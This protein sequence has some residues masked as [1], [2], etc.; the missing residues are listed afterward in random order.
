MTAAVEQVWLDVREPVVVGVS[1]AAVAVRL[2]QR[3]GVVLQHSVG[4]DLHGGCVVVAD[5][6]VLALREELRDLLEPLVAVPPQGSDHACGQASV[7]CE[8]AIG[9]VSPGSDPGVLPSGD[10]E[11]VQVLLRVEDRRLPLLL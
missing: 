5:H 4:H 10:S 11:R 1:A 9:V 8:R 7:V 2:E 6:A 3:A